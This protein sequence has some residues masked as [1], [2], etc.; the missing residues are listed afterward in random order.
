MAQQPAHGLPDRAV[1]MRVIVCGLHRTGTMSTRSALWQLGF[2]DCY[3]MQTVIQNM[4]THPQQWIR[5]YEAKYADKGT[6]T[7][8]DWDKLLGHCQATCD[9]PVA[10]FSAEIAEIYPDAKVIILN[11]DPEL[12]Y[13]SVLNTIYRSIKPGSLWQRFITFYCT[14]LDSPI[15]NWLKFTNTMVRL[16]MPFD[17]GKEKDKAIAWFKSQYAEFRERIP[18]DRRLEFSVKDGW[19]PLCEHL[20]VPVPTIRDD[21][22]GKLVEAP[23]PRVND[24]E[25]FGIISDN[26][27]TQSMK[28]ANRNLVNGLGQVA[29]TGVLGYGGYLAWKTNFWGRI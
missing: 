17:H 15:N 13:D 29:L 6:F 26:I 2:H 16:A 18:E 19:K 23:F 21:K 14:L 9:L 3:H 11:R 20:G 1:P 10:V 28:R 24:R 27:W 5:A 8:A 4:E 12:W 25:S 22:T 7:K